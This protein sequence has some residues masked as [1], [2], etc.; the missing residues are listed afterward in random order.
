MDSCA[1]MEHILPITRDLGSR[2][3]TITRHVRNE[4]HL[5]KTIGMREREWIDAW[6]A[7]GVFA[8]LCSRSVLM[9]LEVYYSLQLNKYP[10]IAP[11]S[12]I[13]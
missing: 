2:E 4:L 7:Y 6:N 3:P 8:L 10:H 11:P 1:N 9:E 12:Q 5:E 13:I